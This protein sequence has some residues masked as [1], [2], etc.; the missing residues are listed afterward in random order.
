MFQSA[1]TLADFI[2]KRLFPAFDSSTSREE[3]RN[4]RTISVRYVG[5]DAAVI[6][7]Y[8][9]GQRGAARNENENL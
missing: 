7:A 1:D 4:M 8:T 5:D 6:H 9:E 2:E 3:I